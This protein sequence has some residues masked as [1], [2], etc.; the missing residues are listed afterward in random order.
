MNYRTCPICGRAMILCSTYAHGQVPKRIFKCG[1]CGFRTDV[2][3][4][5][6]SYSDFLNRYHFGDSN[7]HNKPINY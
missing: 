5:G 1:C 3:M 7:N 2:D 4:S 6:L